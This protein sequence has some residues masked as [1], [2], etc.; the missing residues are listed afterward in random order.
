VCEAD[1]DVLQ[2][3]VDKS[4]VRRTR[5]RY[6]MLETI[7]EYAVERFD[8][9][10]GSGEIRA[11]HAEYVADLVEL[12]DPHLVGPEQQTW[13]DRL[14][15]EY[16]NIRAAMEYALAHAP[17][18]ALR[19]VGAL[20]FYPSLRGGIAEVG[21]WAVEALAAGNDATPARRA[22]ALICAAGMATWQG[23]MPAATRYAEEA[24]AIAVAAGD[25]FVVTAAL[26]ERS[27]AAAQAGDLE[28]ARA[29][30][31]ELRRVAD[32]VGDAF[33]GAIALNNLGDLALYD[34]D[35]ART[36]ELCG[37]SAAIRREM[38]NRWGAALCLGNVALAQRELGLFD[39]AAR[40]LREALDESLAVDAR[41]IVL[42]C[43]AV[44][45]LL[46]ADRDR[47]EDAATL[48]GAY[49]QLNLEL[50]LA[51]D[52]YEGTLIDALR[53]KTTAQLGDAPFARAR[54]H[55]RSLLIEDAAELARTA[56][57]A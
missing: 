10:A 21:V 18:L 27:K 31:E 53:E 34:G 38:G 16:D 5:D 33:N 29:L 1:I 14:S 47:P 41:M 17:E 45:A 54:E 3:L 24:H 20:A 44:G 15:L 46:A 56:S 57:S 7:R 13:A 22:R 12:A 35:W 30:L 55:G 19:I 36:I 42:N 23:D 4:L 9:I 8:A 6:W 11:A 2:S 39:D 37:R 26:R 40:S 49:D 25:G 52:L 50:E 28:A 43:F 51:P 32:E 48:L